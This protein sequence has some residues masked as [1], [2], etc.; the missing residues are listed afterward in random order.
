MPTLMLRLVMML[1]SFPGV[2]QKS[3]VAKILK[4]QEARVKRETPLHPTLIPP[5]AGLNINVAARSTDEQ[6]KVYLLYERNKEALRQRR[7]QEEKAIYTFKPS[8]PK[9]L[10]IVHWLA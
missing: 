2:P 3:K 8:L 6:H 10:V 1:M 4:E 5:L 7:L 9:V